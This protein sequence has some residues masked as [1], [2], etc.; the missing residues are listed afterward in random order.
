MTIQSVSKFGGTA[1]IGSVVRPFAYDGE[2]RNL[3]IG[4]LDADQA[5][6]LLQAL[7][8]GEGFVAPGIGIGQ[9][10]IVTAAAADA[11]ASRAG[12]SP[13][14][15]KVGD[16]NGKSAACPSVA[17]PS[18]VAAAA[19][20]PKPAPAVVDPKPPKAADPE[21]LKA[22]DPEPP[23]AADPEPPK[24]ADPEPPKAETKATP[25]KAEPAKRR[26]GRPK[27]GDIRGDM[28]A[29]KDPTATVGQAELLAKAAP[30]ESEPEPIPAAKPASAPATA[31]E[32][33]PKATA[34]AGGNG[35][36]EE[37]LAAK[38]LRDVVSYW[39]DSGVTDADE[40]VARC[41]AVK[42]KVEVLRRMRN[43]EDRVR[44]A[45]DV[46]GLA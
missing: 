17:D 35:V 22:A 10:T 30:P 31:L 12:V 37:V 16:G 27:A 26:P 25:K 43:V 20:T 14:D 7:G 28:E 6:V 46:L 1:E 3:S 45:I 41:V 21:P 36:P 23:K 33:E 11:A 15:T 29:A 40:I 39:Y 18:V 34:P 38:K 42:D 4:E 19:V 2:T 24:A 8:R 9:E 5:V 13:H 44:R 32:P